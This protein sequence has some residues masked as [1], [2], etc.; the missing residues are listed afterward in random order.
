VWEPEELSNPDLTPCLPQVD[1]LREADGRLAIGVSQLE[2]G[3]WDG[4]VV[5]S[6]IHETEGEGPGLSLQRV[7]EHPTPNGIPDLTWCGSS[8]NRLLVV[9][10]DGGDVLVR[11]TIHCNRCPVSD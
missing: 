4:M 6:T 10:Q 9:A 3:M 11:H 5:I 8:S 1:V 2:G 7:L